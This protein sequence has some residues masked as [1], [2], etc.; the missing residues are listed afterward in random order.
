LFVARMR[1]NPQHR[2]LFDNWVNHGQVRGVGED[3]DAALPSLIEFGPGIPEG[4]DYGLSERILFMNKYYQGHQLH[5]VNE[6]IP[7]YRS[8]T[9]VPVASVP[10][11]AKPVYQDEE[12]AALEQPVEGGE[13]F[14]YVWPEAYYGERH[15]HDF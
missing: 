14:G 15:P 11:G 2:E 9:W 1:L 4:N 13:V 10:A 8:L 3:A 6:F 7:E 5:K 12:F